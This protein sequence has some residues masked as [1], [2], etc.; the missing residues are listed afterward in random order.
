MFEGKYKG[1]KDRCGK[2]RKKVAIKRGPDKEEGKHIIYRAK[3]YNTLGLFR[4]I[5][6]QQAIS[7]NARRYGKRKSVI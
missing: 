4:P 1:R 3:S 2:E 6:R 5:F 7:S